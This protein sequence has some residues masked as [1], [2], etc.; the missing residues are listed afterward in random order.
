MKL[1]PTHAHEH[2]ARDELRTQQSWDFWRGVRVNIWGEVE[3]TVARVLLQ[4]IQNPRNVTGLQ[5]EPIP[6]FSSS[7]ELEFSVHSIRPMEM[8]QS[9][10]IDLMWRAAPLQV[11]GEFHR[12]ELS[13]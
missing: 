4:I 1:Q 11:A 3:V 8:K 13:N 2:G 9:N 5:D 12:F 7:I 10:D 6:T